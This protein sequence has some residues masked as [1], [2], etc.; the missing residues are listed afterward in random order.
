MSTQIQ[1]HRTDT[2][3]PLTLTVNNNGGV[4]GLTA[5]V[6][7][8]DGA[9]TNSYLDFSDNTFKTSGWTTQSGNMGEVGGGVYN[10]SLNANAITNLPAATNHLV[11]EY[12][13]SGSVIGVDSDIVSLRVFSDTD[14]TR[15]Q[16]TYQIMGLDSSNA[17]TVSTTA[18]TAGSISQTISDSSGTVTVTR[19]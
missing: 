14:G 6:K 10:Y 2:S 7:V 8:R 16:E 9:T 11:A 15:V 4:T 18:R 13:V 17:M 5:L 3:I 19:T 12:S 1:A